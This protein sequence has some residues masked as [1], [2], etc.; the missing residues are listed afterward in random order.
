[1]NDLRDEKIKRIEQQL[2]KARIRDPEELRAIVS[3][4]QFLDKINAG[5]NAAQLGRKPKVA[6]VNRPVLPGWIW[7]RV[8]IVFGGLA[9]IPICALS[10]F[11]Y[12]KQDSYASVPGL[13]E[14]AALPEIQRQLVFPE[15]LELSSTDAPTE[16]VKAKNPG[17]RNRIV[18]EKIAFKTKLRKSMNRLLGTNS[19]TRL[20]PA[21][22][23]TEAVFYP[24]A[25]GGDLEEAKKGGQIIR[26]ELT[27]SSLLALGLNPPGE[28]ETL[29]ITTDLLISS[30]GVARG[31]RFVS[32]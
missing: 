26:V 12:I 18:P 5:I 32:Q 13:I 1:M 23:E 16:V 24:L 30:D 27:R 10:I 29:K 25:F 17:G 2:L 19:A 7:T 21:E 22:N 15:N 4:P 31:I 11:F 20:P 14:E 8:G 28:N 3:G 6:F 9:L